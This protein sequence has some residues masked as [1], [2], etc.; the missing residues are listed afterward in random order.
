MLSFFQIVYIL[1]ATLQ[2]CGDMI[3]YALIII[4]IIVLLI[5][6]GVLFQQAVNGQK[7]NRKKCE[8]LIE[9][10]LRGVSGIRKDQTK[11]VF[12][13]YQDVMLAKEGELTSGNI[14]SST[15]EEQEKLGYKFMFNEFEGR[16][17]PNYSG[18]QDYLPC[19]TVQTKTTFR[20]GYH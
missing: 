5:T 1:A 7:S 19:S 16:M 13:S 6:V 10:K 18:R 11:K 14:P 4:L 12:G 8:K 20:D 9:N 15:P 17:A 3:A 2:L